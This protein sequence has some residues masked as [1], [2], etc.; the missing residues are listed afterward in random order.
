MNDIDNKGREENKRYANNMKLGHLNINS[1]GGFKLFEVKT[2]LGEN[3][4]DILVLS[5][6]KI[7]NNLP[8]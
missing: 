8:G 5:E 1:I 2:C 6:T 7:D 3:L 4:F